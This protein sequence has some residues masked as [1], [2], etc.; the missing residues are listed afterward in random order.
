MTDREIIEKIEARADRLAKVV[1]VHR[2]ALRELKSGGLECWCNVAP[3]DYENDSKHS[4]GCRVARAADQGY[5]AL[6]P[7]DVEEE[8]HAA[9]S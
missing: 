8:I 9:A 6:Q 7:G 3:T 1:R 2:N 5:A 4:S